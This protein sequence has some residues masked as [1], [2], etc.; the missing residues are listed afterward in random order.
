MFVWQW[1]G[2][3]ITIQSH[4]PFTKSKAIDAV[5]VHENEHN[6]NMQITQ[7]KYL[8]Q[9][10]SAINWQIPFRWWSSVDRF[11]LFQSF[12]QAH[13]IPWSRFYSWMLCRVRIL[14]EGS[15]LSVPYREDIRLLAITSV[16]NRPPHL[17]LRNGYHVIVVN[18]LGSLAQA[19]LVGPEDSGSTWTGLHF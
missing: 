7:T 1:C 16:K 6:R 4:V 14:I 18:F 2:R 13:A 19:K 9:T 15:R 17:W 10:L 8:R 3:I 12:S 11:V 5:H